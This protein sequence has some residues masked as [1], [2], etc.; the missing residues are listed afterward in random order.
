LLK[1]EAPFDHT[2]LKRRIGSNAFSSNEVDFPQKLLK[3]WTREG[4]TKITPGTACTPK[5][6]QSFKK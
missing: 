3:N 6:D 4:N 2:E 5:V 1:A